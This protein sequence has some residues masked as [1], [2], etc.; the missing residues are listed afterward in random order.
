MSQGQLSVVSPTQGETRHRTAATKQHNQLPDSLDVL[1]LLLFLLSSL[2]DQLV[3]LRELLWIYESGANPDAVCRAWW[4]RFRYFPPVRRKR[5][6]TPFPV[7]SCWSAEAGQAS[8]DERRLN[9]FCA[10]VYVL[11]ICWLLDRHFCWEA[12][13]ASGPAASRALSPIG[14]KRRG[15]N[16]SEGG[17]QTTDKPST[18]WWKSEERG[19]GQKRKEKEKKEREQG[20]FPSPCDIDG[21]RV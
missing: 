9:S 4:R 14:V 16:I 11:D 19:K 17:K 12:A 20:P 15:G 10:C 6:K 1:F 2:V 7:S 13:L 3:T 18:A 21:S 8:W 5:R